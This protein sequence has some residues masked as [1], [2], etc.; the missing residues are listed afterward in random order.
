MRFFLCKIKL[1][2][3]Y[4]KYGRKVTTYEEITIMCLCCTML[5]K[6]NM[7]YPKNGLFKAKGTYVVTITDKA[8]NKTTASFTIKNY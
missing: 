6:K 5:D 1:F 2:S 4:Y 8:G 7:T 3:S